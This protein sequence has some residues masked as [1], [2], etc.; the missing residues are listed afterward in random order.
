MQ[1]ISIIYSADYD[2]QILQ[3]LQGNSEAAWEYA[4]QLSED[5]TFKEMK[6]DHYDVAEFD[7]TS[8]ANKWVLEQ[9]K[10]SRKNKGTITIHDL[11]KKHPHIGDYHYQWRN[12]EEPK[13]ERDIVNVLRDLGYCMSDDDQDEFAGTY[14]D[15]TGYFNIDVKPI[16][17][18]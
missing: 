12:T 16:D 3:F 11:F 4:N 13:K 7:N 14:N 15:I 18:K 9:V 5:G 10:E 2:F 17:Q 8:E 1:K 6:V